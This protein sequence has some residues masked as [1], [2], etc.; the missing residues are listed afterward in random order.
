MD[1]VTWIQIQLFAFQAVQFIQTV[2]IYTIQF[3][4]SMRFVY[5][6]LNVKAFKC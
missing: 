2:L 6:Q 4:V 1:T 5:R 3:I